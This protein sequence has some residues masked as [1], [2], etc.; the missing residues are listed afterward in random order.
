MGGA[1]APGNIRGDKAIEDVRRPQSTVRRIGKDVTC[2]W[3]VSF[4]TLA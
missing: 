4:L 1:D 3:I 2:D